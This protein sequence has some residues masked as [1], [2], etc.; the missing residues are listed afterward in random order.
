[1]PQVRSEYLPVDLSRNTVT[2]VLQKLL[3]AEVV[4]TGE[5]R[6]AHRAKE[7]Q[8]KEKKPTWKAHGAFMSAFFSFSWAGNIL[9]LP[10]REKI[11]SFS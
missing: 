7:N 5:K 1:M 4:L 9:A 11:F 3:L 10:E 8:R 2:V 6:R